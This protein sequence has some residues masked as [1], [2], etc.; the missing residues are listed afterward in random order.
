MEEIR[1]WFYS[2]GVEN[3][4][5]DQGRCK[6]SF[7]FK[8]GWCLGPQDW[9]WWSSAPVFFSG[10]FSSAEGLT[11]SVMCISRGGPRTLPPGCTIVS[12][13]L[14]PLPSLMSN[15]LNLPFGPQGRS[16]TLK[17]IPQKQEMGDT[18]NLVPR[19]PSSAWLHWLGDL[20]SVSMP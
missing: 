19:S 8:V 4:A 12:W 11:D 17:L 18:E 6:L 14:Q 9:F 1:K 10:G 20:E 13:S 15:C 2:L 5:T 7:F 16:W 3:R